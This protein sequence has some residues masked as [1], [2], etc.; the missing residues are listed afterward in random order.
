MTLT[1]IA[2]AALTAFLAGYA[3]M[4]AYRL[5]TLN[6]HHARAMRE[7]NQ[8]LIDRTPVM[9]YP[10]SLEDFMETVYPKNIHFQVQQ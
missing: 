2:L 10:P 8:R 7:L 3:A 6:L 9:V 5:R 1:L 4:T